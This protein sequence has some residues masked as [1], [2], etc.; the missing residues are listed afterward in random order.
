MSTREH[1]DG[2]G[3]SPTVPLGAALV[4]AGTILLLDR[5]ELLDADAVLSD[6]WPL[7]LVAAGAWWLV[8]GSRLAGVV[9][10]VVGVLVLATTLDL[11][12]ASVAE[13]IFPV[14]LVALGGAALSAGARTRAAAHRPARTTAS[15]GRQ[16]WQEAATA[17]AVFGDARLSVADDGSPAELTAVTAVS[18]FGDVEVDVPHGWRIV[19]RTTSLLGTV[20]VP[21]DQPAAA[22]APVVELHGLT[23]FGDATVRYAGTTGKV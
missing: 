22:D 11:V 5:A 6:W 14:L 9:T 10:M 23:V 1:P 18:V 3:A 20:R 7:A 17:V 16:Q 15:G 2:R 8:A 12:D 21:H 13:L 4:A 19:D